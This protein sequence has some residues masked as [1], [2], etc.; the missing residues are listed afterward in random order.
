MIIRYA[1]VVVAF[2]AQA[3]VAAGKGKSEDDCPENGFE[4]YRQLD[5]KEVDMMVETVVDKDTCMYEMSISFTP[6]LTLPFMDED[7]PLN[8]ANG[9]IA[10]LQP[11]PEEPEKRTAWHTLC[12]AEGRSE[13]EPIPGFPNNHVGLQD[14]YTEYEYTMKLP[15]N[16][17]KIT[18]ID[19]VTMGANPCGRRTQ[20]YTSYSAHFYYASIKD[21]KK[22]TCISD[23]GFICKDSEYQVCGRGLKFNTNGSVM[24]CTDGNSENIPANIPAGHSW[25]IEQTILSPD[26]WGQKTNSAAPGMG[27][28]AINR[29]SFAS[30]IFD[31]PTFAMVGHDQKIGAILIYNWSGFSRGYSSSNDWEYQDSPITYNC[32]DMEKYGKLPTHVGA[33]YSMESGRTTYTIRGPAGKCKDFSHVKLPKDKKTNKHASKKVKKEGVI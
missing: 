2:F 30:Q 14:H 7:S 4:V 15:K 11:F 8:G 19:H 10:N 17:K 20:P 27:F 24:T 1:C 33:Q 28:I 23:G 31:L 29:Q 25:I 21:R 13:R 32:Q 16:V 9:S 26:F 5:P 3:A 12:D 18:G 6:D 22:M